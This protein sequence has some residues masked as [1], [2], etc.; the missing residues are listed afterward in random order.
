MFYNIEKSLKKKI[1]SDSANYRNSDKFSKKLLIIAY[2]FPPIPY[3]GT[4]RALRLC[5]GLDRLGVEVH[6]LTI[7]Q[8]DD[9]PN[10]YDLL[11]QLPRSVNIHRTPILDPWRRYQAF[12]SKYVN[13]KGFR[14]VN[15]VMSLIL[16]IITIPD[17]MVLWVPFAV[18]RGI[19]IIKDQDIDT[20]FVSSPPNSSQLIGYFLSKIKKVKW[21]ADLRDPICGNIAETNLM[22]PSD[23]IS[24]VEKKV[25]IRY[26]N[27]IVNNAEVI[28]ANTET[29]RRELIDKFKVDK[30]HA[31]RN[32]F[33]EDEYKD[34]GIEKYANFTI[35][36]A[37]SMYGLRKA[38]VLFKAIKNLE[39]RLS[40]GLLNLQILFVGL[41]D[42]QL[43]K[44][45]K[46][47]DVEKYVKIEK[48]V[49]HKESI[50]IMVNSHLLLLIK[51]TGKGSYGQIPGKF[52]EYL[53]AKNKILYLGP[54]ESEVAEIINSLD[55]GYV[56]GDDVSAISSKLRSEYDAFLNK[57][58]HQI[59][60][61][62]IADYNCHNMSKE[63]YNLL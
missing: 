14:Y 45:V 53:G 10:D 28:I 55:V 62:R 29:H 33:D 1:N 51:G 57:E 48:M 5:K 12:K 61:G 58:I 56:I 19:K 38:D 6:V 9:I 63:I 34:I 32:A 3:G 36:H 37:G 52:F 2:T 21:I 4:Y 46:Y 43:E 24:K 20:V 7:N 25:R 17:H 31:V 47:Y 50:Q 40:P 59:N 8:Y 22:S 30:F 39:A 15:K 44:E 49:S 16:K 54:R 35:S 23:F 42:P 27:F 26:E 13:I 60:D 41:S 11:S 18:L